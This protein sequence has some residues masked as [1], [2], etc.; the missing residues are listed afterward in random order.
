[1]IVARKYERA[2]CT[3]TETRPCEAITN[4]KIG[5]NVRVRLTLVLPKQ[6]TMCASQIRCPPAPK[7]STRRC[8]PVRPPTDNGG[9]SYFGGRFGWGWWW[10]ASTEVRDDNVQM[11]ASYLP[12]GTY[13]FTY[14]MRPSIVGDFT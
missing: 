7:R 2:D 8:A 11:F 5:D 12:A 9:P 4:A 14:E 3:P 6:P 1:M 10:V 13:E